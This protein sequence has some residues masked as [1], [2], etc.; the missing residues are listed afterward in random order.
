MDEVQD[1]MQA[2]D[3]TASAVCVVWAPRGPG[4]P[5]VHTC[6]FFVTPL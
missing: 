4:V 1:Q 2:E 6:S 5:C 3:A